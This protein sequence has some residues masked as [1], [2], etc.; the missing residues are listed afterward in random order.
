MLSKIALCRSLG[1]YAG[2]DLLLLVIVIVVVA[3]DVVG[4]N[5]AGALLTSRCLI[6]LAH[7]PRG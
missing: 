3:S 4:S 1:A 6:P 7:V 2:P 5:D